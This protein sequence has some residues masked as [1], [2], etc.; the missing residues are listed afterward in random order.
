MALWGPRHTARLKKCVLSAVFE[1][2]FM[3]I[4]MQNTH[5]YEL[6]KMYLTCSTLNDVKITIFCNLLK[7]NNLFYWPK[8]NSP[9]KIWNFILPPDLH[10]IQPTSR[11]DVCMQHHKEGLAGAPINERAPPS[12]FK[13]INPE[14][15]LNKTLHWGRTGFRFT[16]K[17]L[18]KHWVPSL[19]ASLRTATSLPVLSTSGLQ[20]V[21]GP[22]DVCCSL[23]SSFLCLDGPPLSLPPYLT[24]QAPPFCPGDVSLG[25]HPAWSA[26]PTASPLLWVRKAMCSIQRPWHFP[27]CIWIIHF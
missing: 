10:V 23:L 3:P 7:I 17:G 22:L 4:Q 5:Q 15:R 27:Y 24:T 21:S 6:T 14:L 8:N 19:W 9:I 13:L 18:E 26:F 2:H 1:Y 12:P 16:S 25:P 11:K 20:N